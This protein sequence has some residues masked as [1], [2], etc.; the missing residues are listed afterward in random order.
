MV[1][2]IQDGVIKTGLKEK[3]QIIENFLETKFNTT[4]DREEIVLELSDVENLGVPDKVFTD[5]T[6]H[7][8]V[9]PIILM[10]LSNNINSLV[11]E[12]RQRALTV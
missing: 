8:M 12:E 1:N 9:R 6:A 11:S 4:Y 3:N 10:E 5:H 7:E 2:L